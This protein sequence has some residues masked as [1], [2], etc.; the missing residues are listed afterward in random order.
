VS[1]KAIAAAVVGGVAITGGR[2]SVWGVLLSCLFLATLERTHVY[3][4]VQAHWQETLVGSVLVLAVFLGWVIALIRNTRLSLTDSLWW[5]VSTGAAL[6]VTLFPRSL[7]WVAHAL[8]IEV[9]ANALFAFA[10]IYVLFNLLSITLTASAQS[11]S[12]RRLAQQTAIL[13]AELDALTS[14]AGR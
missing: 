13:Q 12:I 10:F 11:A 9:P 5:L 7:A 4:G 1:P 3:L 6:V 8:S 2:G 14:R